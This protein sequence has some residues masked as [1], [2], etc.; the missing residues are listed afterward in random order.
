MVLP[1]ITSG[2]G[3][4]ELGGGIV[5]LFLL[6]TL[7]YLAMICFY[8]IRGGHA[9]WKHVTFREGIQN[10]KDTIKA[11]KGRSVLTYFTKMREAFDVL[12]VRGEWEEEDHP[13]KK[14]V[15]HTSFVTRS[16]HLKDSLAD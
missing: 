9:A 15:L 7:T 12:V 3:S 4:Y 14:D 1:A 11:A 8:G 13:E 6:V 10:M 2:C 5:L 16:P